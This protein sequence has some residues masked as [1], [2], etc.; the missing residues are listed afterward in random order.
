[1]Q[2]GEGKGEDV[3]GEAPPP[4][5]PPARPSREEPPPPP[6]PSECRRGWRAGR[7]GGPELAVGGSRESTPTTFSSPLDGSGGVPAAAAD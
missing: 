2:R 5:P 3:V 1:M 7:S 4:P 6:R